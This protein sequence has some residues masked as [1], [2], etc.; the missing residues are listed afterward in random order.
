MHATVSTVKLQNKVKAPNS[1][2]SFTHDDRKL[3]WTPGAS[4]GSLGT[5]RNLMML[6]V[7]SERLAWQL[8]SVCEWEAAVK[9]LI[10]VLYKWT[11]YFSF[12]QHLSEPSV[13][14]WKWPQQRFEQ[15]KNDLRSDESHHNRNQIIFIQIQDL[16]L[17]SAGSYV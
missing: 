11:F 3:A 9:M 13:D 1:S 8:L 4:W 5:T 14:N 16:H 7:V 17:I 2:F 10:K 15:Y 12:A 6:L